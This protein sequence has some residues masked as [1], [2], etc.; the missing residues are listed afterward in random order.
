MKCGVNQRD[1]SHP[2]K[3]EKPLFDRQSFLDRMQ[4]RAKERKWQATKHQHDAVELAKSLDDMKSVG[5]Y[6]RLVK[7][8]DLVA[9]HRCRDWVLKTAK[10]DKGRMFVSVFRRFLPK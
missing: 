1:L 8:Y 2:K 3:P 9:L 7:R 10:M 4:A 5:I 6:M